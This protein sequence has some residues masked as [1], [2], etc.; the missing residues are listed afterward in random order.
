MLR[1]MMKN[2]TSQTP[3]TVRTEEED[4]DWNALS[5]RIQKLAHRRSRSLLAD[6]DEDA[7][8]RGARALRTLMSAAEV[9]NRMKRE[10]EKERETDDRRASGQGFTEADIEEAYRR[11]SDTVDRLAQEDAGSR[12]GDAAHQDRSVAGSGA[13]GSG[14]TVAGER[15]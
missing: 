7:F 14:E 3:E 12:S 15:S 2:Q 4:E 8:D 10:E 11:V 9:A 6:H 5:A 13:A 1:S